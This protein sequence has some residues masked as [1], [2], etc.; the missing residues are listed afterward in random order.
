MP[1]DELD[2]LLRDRF[3]LERADLIAALKTLPKHVFGK[4]LEC[5]DE[6]RTF[7]VEPVPKKL[8]QFISGHCGA[9]PP[10]G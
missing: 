8:V 4:R 10:H 2:E 5:S 7:Q 3:D 1:A 9:P 6:V